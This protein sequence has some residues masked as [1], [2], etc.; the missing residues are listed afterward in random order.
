MVF[1]VGLTVIKLTP[2]APL[3]QVT[4]PVQPVWVIL[5]DSP[6]Q[7]AETGDVMVGGVG[8]GLTVSVA[9][10]LTLLMQVVVLSRH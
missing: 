5:T 10:A 8:F 9:V 3:L 1:A 4:V 7:M 6:V 2:D